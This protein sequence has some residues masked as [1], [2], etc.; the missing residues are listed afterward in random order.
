MKF[1]GFKAF[2]KILACADEAELPSL[3][4]EVFVRLWTYHMYGKDRS[5]NKVAHEVVS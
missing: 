2:S 1:W 3:M 5:L 4:T